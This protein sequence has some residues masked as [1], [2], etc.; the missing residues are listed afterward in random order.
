M[1]ITWIKDFFKWTNIKKSF[2]KQILD[3]NFKKFNLMVKMDLDMFASA[4]T[5]TQANQN[6][7]LLVN[8]VSGTKKFIKN[9]K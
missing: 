4:D 5:L 6:A 7:E 1:Y 3:H 8:S 9:L 2:K